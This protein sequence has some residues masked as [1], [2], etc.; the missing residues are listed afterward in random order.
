MQ[1]LSAGE[2]PYYGRRRLAHRL[3]RLRTAEAWNQMLSWTPGVG[4]LRRYLARAGSTVSRMVEPVF[5]HRPASPIASAQPA[6]C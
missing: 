3:S 4:T 2:A 5:G 1:H 6:A